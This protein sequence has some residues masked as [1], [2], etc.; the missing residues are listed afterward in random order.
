MNVANPEKRSQKKSWRETTDARTPNNTFYWDSWHNNWITSFFSQNITTIHF[1]ARR[2]KGYDEIREEPDKNVAVQQN[3]SFCRTRTKNKP[4]LRARF[5]IGAP[6]AAFGEARPSS[7]PFIRRDRVY[8][9]PKFIRTKMFW[10][11]VS[12]PRARWKGCRLRC[13]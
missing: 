7:A 11:V 2:A 5:F 1:P 8:T 9:K 4:T 10:L 13:E 6:N 12:A 3:V